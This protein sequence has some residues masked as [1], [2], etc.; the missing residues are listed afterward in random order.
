MDNFVLLC[1]VCFPLYKPQIVYY[2][3]LMRKTGKNSYEKVRTIMKKD[4]FIRRKRITRFLHTIQAKIFL[5]YGSIFLLLIFLVSIIYYSTSYRNFLENQ[6]HTS[7]QLSKIISSQLQQ[8]LDS[9]NDIQ[10]RILESEDILSYIF[11]DAQKKNVVLDR[12]FRENIYSITGYDFD[13]YHM[14]IY[15]LEDHT[16]LTFGQNYDYKEYTPESSV[17]KS[18]IKPALEKSGA[19]CLFPMNTAPLYSPVKDTPTAS[20][21]RAFGRYS[22]TTPK[23][24]LEIQVSFSRIQEI[25]AD[26]VLS[27]GNAEEQIFIYTRDKKPLYPLKFPDNF[28]DYYAELP[29]DDKFL[30]K[31]PETGGAELVTAYDSSFYKLTTMLLTPEEYLISNRR[32]FQRASLG[33]FGISLLLLMFLT[34]KVAKSISSPLTALKNRISALELESISEEPQLPVESEFFSEVEV[35]NESY[36]RMQKRLRKSLDDIVASRTLTMHAQLMSLQAQMDA[37]FLYNTL[38]IISIIAE[39]NEDMEASAMCI[40]L[41][42]M[43][44]YT[45]EDYSK[46]TSLMQELHHCQNYTDLMAIRFGSKIRFTY[47]VEET[48]LPVHVPRLIMQPV[49]EN[50]V[51]YSRKEGMILRISVS[52][53]AEDGWW[54]LIVRDNG[55]GFTKESLAQIDAR[56]SRLNQEKAHPSL[57]IDGLGLA[58]IYLRMKLYYNNRFLF[59]LGNL[60]EEN[61]SGGA[62]I[63]IGGPYH[64]V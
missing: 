22:L 46:D 48:L 35:L 52:V 54:K 18:L 51:K 6:A 34:F 58:N 11:E 25:I 39:E 13:F 47:D 21:L 16:L 1:S 30:F 29:V 49:V 59:E 63:T 27:Y 12:K 42:E 33:I 37:H 5:S 57:S 62:I 9:V 50:C 61:S 19:I 31:N 36:N 24:V 53:T 7:R 28:T 23:A 26:T 3:E 15:N 10:K 55:D 43:L 4:L 64:E 56:I 32:L 44:R 60:Q 41:T 38:T 40:K 8:Y 14:N 17:E 2:I 45:T 20:L